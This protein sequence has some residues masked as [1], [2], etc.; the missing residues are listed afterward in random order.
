MLKRFTLRRPSL[1]IVNRWLLLAIIIVNGYIIAI[2][3]LPRVSYWWSEHFNHT[4]QQ[5]E[6]KV[7]TSPKTTD[8][9]D[10]PKDN[11]LVVPSMQ[12]DAE[13][14]EGKSATTLRQGIWHR[15]QTSTPD[16]GGNTVL[17]GHRFTYT[18]PKG[19]FYYLDKVSLDERI[20]LY[21]QGT[22]YVY[23]V[24]EIKVVPP[25][26]ISVEYPTSDNRLTLY[27]CTPLWSPKQRLV[28]IATLESKS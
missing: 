4:S 26:E 15:P 27:T 9:P 22:K 17:A 2:P 8:T 16:K 5:L 21:W 10:I 25:T 12:L 7:S 11:R 28:V 13:I 19:I 20:A 1:S 3:V 24:T 23:K 14:F 6:A 18:E